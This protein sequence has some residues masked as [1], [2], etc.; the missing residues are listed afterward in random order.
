M[1]K[2]SLAAKLTAAKAATNN[3]WRHAAS[4]KAFVQK[5]ANK[6][7]PSALKSAAKKSASKPKSAAKKSISKS[8]SAAKKSSRK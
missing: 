7:K 6:L 1:A 2:V 4:E 3:P 5:N 8:K